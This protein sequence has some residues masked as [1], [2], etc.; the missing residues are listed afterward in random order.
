MKF[1]I[2]PIGNETLRKEIVHKIDHKTK[3]VGS[4]GQ[5]EDLALKM[6]MIQI[7]TKIRLKKPTIV[8]FAG[9]HGLTEEGVSPFPQEVTRQMMS[10]FIAGGAAVSVFSRQNHMEIKLIDCGIKDALS[11]V[12][13]KDC[14]LGRGTNNCLKGAA[15]TKDQLDRGIAHGRALSKRLL[16][17]GC[18]VFGCGEMGIGNSSIAALIAARLT[19]RPITDLAGPGTGCDEKQMS[20]KIKILAEVDAK[21][22]EAKTPVDV[23][24]TMGGFEQ[25]TALGAMLQAAENRQ[26]ILVDGFIM[27]AVALC[28]IKINPSC[29]DYMIFCHRSASPGHKIILEHLAVEPLLDLKMRLGEGSGV[30]VAYPIVE[31]AANFLN[32][33]ASFESASVSNKS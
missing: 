10:N 27:S 28:A 11:H 4:L 5:L 8:I 23:L 20:K 2:E 29:L 14:R 16:A 22:K 3:P 21:H 9:D 7:D 33:M 31:A 6:A 32:D 15:M 24:Q 30:A 1:K 25:A 12:K 17:D 26:I 19:G 13:I 18:N